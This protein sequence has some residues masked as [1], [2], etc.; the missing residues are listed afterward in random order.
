M[1][2]SFSPKDEIWFLRVCHHISNAVY[3]NLKHSDALPEVGNLES[4][5]L[6]LSRLFRVKIKQV[7]QAGEKL[8]CYYCGL[9]AAIVQFVK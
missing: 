2:S 4:K 6:S 1:D 7:K 8:W 9:I 5:L 3:A